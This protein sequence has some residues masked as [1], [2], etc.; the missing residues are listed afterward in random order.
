MIAI[1]S[2]SDYKFNRSCGGF[3]FPG[4]GV[5]KE[6][7]D[8]L[9]SGDEAAFRAMVG[10]FRDRVLNT[11]FRFLPNRQDAE[12]AAQDVF[13]EIYRSLPAFREEAELSTWVYRVAVTKSLGVLRK[14]K[15]KKR[16]DAV[17]KALKVGSGIESLPS[18][19]DSGP[20]RTLE[21]RERSRIL[22][23]A[24]EKLPENQEAAITLSQYEGLDNKAIAGIL[25]TT[26]PAVD[27][28][29]HR[30]KKNL[31]RMLWRHYAKTLESEELK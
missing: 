19:A 12:D 29:I 26:V 10:D 11:C 30:A 24:I 9:R 1:R 17:R 22:R 18:P 15:R 31:K 8:K 14:M 3:H 2:G 4:D 28:L 5:D 13:V 23:E 21:I 7:L 27:S 6:F 20:E 25:G 16:F